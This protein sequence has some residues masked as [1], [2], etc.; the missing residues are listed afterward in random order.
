VDKLEQITAYADA[1]VEDYGFEAAMVQARQRMVIEIIARERPRV[2]LEVG[3]GADMLHEKAT[4]AGVAFEQWLTVEPAA[5]FYECARDYAATVQKMTVIRGFFE[6]TVDAIRGQVADG[7]DMILLS[8]N[9]HEV[10]DPK[11]LLTAARSLLGPRGLLH[12]SVP[13]ALSLHRRLAVEM[14]LIAAV[15][16]TSERQKAL[17]QR[18]VYDPTSLRAL[19]TRAGFEVAELGGYLIKPF[20]HAQMEAIGNIV[21]VEMLD[22]LW[23]LGREFPELASEIYVNAR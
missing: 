16:S 6:D 20:T 12:V 1:Y 14:G 3:C 22:G 5:Y 11:V 7:P 8:G 9:L 10:L 17:N 15:D 23:K 18:I 4:A 13:S 19:V 2:V 21:S